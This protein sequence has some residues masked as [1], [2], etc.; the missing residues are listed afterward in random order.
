MGAGHLNSGPHVYT[1]S[2]LTPDPSQQPMLSPDVEP[3]L[4]LDDFPAKSVGRVQIPNLGFSG[5]LDFPYPS[6]DG[7]RGGN[8][9]LLQCSSPE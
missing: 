4:V 1:A 9:Q 2:A 8:K 6:H 5:H 7:Q 3:V